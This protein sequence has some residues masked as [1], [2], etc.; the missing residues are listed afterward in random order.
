M[1]WADVTYAVWAFVAAGAALLGT[2]A[3]R[4]WRVRRRRITR[5]SAIVARVLGRA[6]WVRLV[7]LLG[8]IWV[9]VHFFAR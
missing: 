8:W 2:A 7:F 6:M 4:G 5:P 9:G 1:T 3:L